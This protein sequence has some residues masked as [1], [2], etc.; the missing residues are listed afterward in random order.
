MKQLHF[1]RLGIYLLFMGG[2]LIAYAGTATGASCEPLPPTSGNI[3]N[4]DSVSSLQSA[5]NNALSGD[6]IL[7]A[8][9]VYNLDGV[10]LRIDVPNVRLR[11]A[12]GNRNAVVLD[13]N[14]Q[15]TEII[16]ITASEVTIADITL[17]EALHHPIHVWR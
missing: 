17:R 8:D 4:V 13:G 2:S 1:V 12:S 9:G 6:T 14:Y 5:V 11:S 3:V 10:Y 15:T 7:I 16:Q